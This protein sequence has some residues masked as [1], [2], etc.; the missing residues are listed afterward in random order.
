MTDAVGPVANPTSKWQRRRDPDAPLIEIR[1]LTKDYGSVRAVDDLDLEV[2]A[3]EVLGFLGPNG[4]GKSTAIRVLLDLIRPTRGSAAIVGHDCQ[5]EGASARAHAGYLPGELRLAERWHGDAV[6]RYLTRLR[7]HPPRDREITAL[8]DRLDLDLSRRVSTYSKGN[9]Q[10]LGLLLALVHR[11]SVLILDEPTSGLDPMH[12]RTVWELLRERAA[13]GSAVL[14]SSHVMS[15]VETVCDRV[16]V[17]R[18][19]RLLRLD[20]LENLLAEAPTRLEITFE[21]TPAQLA[22][23][24]GAHDVGVDGRRVSLG[25]DGDPNQLIARLATARLDAA[26]V[27]PPRLDEVVLLLY[28]MQEEQ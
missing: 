5:R 7:D 3:G 8:A 23:L 17:L 18:Q 10:K 13:D 22:D 21:G 26:V 20:R 14:F 9:R 25:Y 15:E 1:G 2:H 12:Q 27:H 28:R 4:A 16:A 24:D 11:P 6:V 19:G